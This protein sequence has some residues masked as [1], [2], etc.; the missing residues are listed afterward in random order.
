VRRFRRTAPTGR[1]YR[2]QPTPSVTGRASTRPGPPLTGPIGGRL[3]TLAE[4]LHLS[5]AVERDSTI[6]LDRHT[7]IVPRQVALARRLA[8]TRADALRAGTVEQAL[9]ELW[10]ELG[11]CL[12]T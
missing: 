9:M 6:V 10:D 11:A 2:C 12:S 1:L 3:A 5:W 4:V 8:G 7:A